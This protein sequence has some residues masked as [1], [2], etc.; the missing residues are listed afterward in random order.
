MTFPVKEITIS[1]FRGIL[2]PLDIDFTKGEPQSMIIYGK[3]GTG[4]SSI[5]D[6]CEWFHREEIGHLQREGAGAGSF[7]HRE[8]EPGETYVEIEFSDDDLE[9]STLTYDHDTITRPVESGDVDEFRRRAPHPFYIR[10]EDLKQFV[11]KTK[12]EKYE[13]LAEL[14]GFQ[15]Q[16]EFQKSLKR[17]R[18]QLSE[19]LEKRRNTVRQREKDLQDLL[20]VESASKSS[21]LNAITEVFERN[22]LGTPREKADLRDAR[23]ILKEKVESDKVASRISQLDQLS[24]VLDKLGELEDQ[25]GPLAEYLKQAQEFAEKEESTVDAL[26]VKLYETGEQVLEQQ[27]A[28]GDDA[29]SCPLCGQP[30]EGDLASHVQNELESLRSLKETKEKVE[31]SFQQAREAIRNTKR[32]IGAAPSGEDINFE[33]GEYSISSLNDCAVRISETIGEVESIL[34]NREHGDLAQHTSLLEDELSSLEDQVDRFEEQRSTLCGASV[35]EKKSLE[36]DSNREQLVGDYSRVRDT[37]DQWEKLDQAR[38]QMS[39][40]EV[41]FD[42]YEEA[43]EDY[44]QQNMTDVKERFEGISADVKK[45]FEILEESTEG[46]SEP[47]I[48]L[49]A[50]KD[51]AVRLKVKFHGKD[52]SPAYKYLSESQLNSF[53]LSVFLASVNRFN[54]EFKFVILDDIINSFDGYKRL[55]VIDLI[56]DELSSHQFLIL[57]HD[58]VW[59][60]QISERFPRWNKIRFEEW[61]ASY[62]PVEGN[63]SVGLEY[64]EDLLEEDRPKTAGRELGAFLERQLQLLCELAEATVKYNRKNEYS[65]RPLLTRLRVRVSNKLKHDHDLTEALQNLEEASTFRNFCAH[66]KNPET[67]FTAEEIRNIMDKWREIDSYMSCPECNRFVSYDGGNF[68]CDCDQTIITKSS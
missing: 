29:V 32:S 21:I 31:Q 24:E 11:Y 20:E 66:W 59:M 9:A 5:T 12:T 10:F 19:R 46:I 35:K 36:E 30:Y 52:T 45:Y 22:D 26:L 65:L 51:R 28:R 3:N 39:Q 64:I 17:V 15:P 61:K 60:K 47:A 14:M 1:G 54:S 43:V 53:G 27:P 4:K 42:S 67:P 33:A 55:K 8:A 41:I 2:Q 57:T 23:N 62:G 6:A 63:S 56:K 44:I 49:V 25:I 38:S 50:D 7:P 37:L 58:R 13:K 40:L 34:D 18:N 16:V 68:S 48:Q